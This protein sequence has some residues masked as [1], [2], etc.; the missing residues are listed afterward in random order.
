LAKRSKD[1]K[2]TILS[3]QEQNKLL[4][5]SMKNLCE[6]DIDIFFK[7]VAMTVKKML[8]Q[9]IKEAKHVDY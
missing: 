9:V 2:D 3:I 5:T 6:D 1:T 8:L 4:V 7:S